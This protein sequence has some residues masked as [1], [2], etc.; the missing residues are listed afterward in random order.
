[1]DGTG[2]GIEIEIG[3]GDRDRGR[4]KGHVQWPPLRLPNAS[5]L[6]PESRPNPNRNR[7]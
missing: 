4:D 2:F 5:V 7:N 3:V 1:M 6:T